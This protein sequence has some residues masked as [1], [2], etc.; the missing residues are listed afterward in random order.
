M[1]VVNIDEVEKIDKDGLHKGDIILKMNDNSL[2]TINEVQQILKNL[3]S[4]SIV[5][6]LV[7]REGIQHTVNVAV[8]LKN[9]IRSTIKEIPNPTER[10]L[11]IRQGILEGNVK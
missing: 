1:K 2:P 10:Q 5:R 11:A 6:L 3:R 9:L 7:D 8:T 4:G